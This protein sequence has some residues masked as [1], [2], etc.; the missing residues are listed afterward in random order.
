MEVVLR[1]QFPLT[2]TLSATVLKF[3][4][5]ISTI[6]PCHFVLPMLVAI[7]L[8]HLV[9]LHHLPRMFLCL[10]VAEFFFRLLFNHQLFLSLLLRFKG[11]LQFLLC[12]IYLVVD[13]LHELPSFPFH[14][15]FTSVSDLFHF[16]LVF[17][18]HSVSFLQ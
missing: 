2:S 14:V 8:V 13:S 16:Y 9:S 17:A 18:S 4:R 1:T 11:L 12:W 3:V 5:V 6:S 10:L 15:S 7:L